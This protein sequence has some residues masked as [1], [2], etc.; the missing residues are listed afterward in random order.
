MNR[1]RLEILKTKLPNY[2]CT[3]LPDNCSMSVEQFEFYSI[4]SYHNDTYTKNIS[5]QTYDIYFNNIVIK[6]VRSSFVKTFY[7][8]LINIKG[9]MNES[10]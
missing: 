3:V 6:K 10:N 4:I 9:G 1:D 5:K 7:N 8:N 2:K